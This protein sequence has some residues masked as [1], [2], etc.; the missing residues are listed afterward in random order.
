MVYR[1]GVGDGQ[2]PY[3]MENEVAAIEGCFKAA[4][5]ENIKFTFIIVS[6]RIMTRFF[7][8]TG[9]SSNN[10]HSGSIFDDVV[11]LPERYD[12]FL[13]SQS[14]RQGT[15]N[16]TSYNIIEDTSMWPANIIQLLTYKLTHLYFNW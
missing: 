8:G 6:K 12:F 11:T 7:T 1:D 13:V 15:V 10:P 9:S 2:I 14:V 5:M 16:P 4:G 3:V